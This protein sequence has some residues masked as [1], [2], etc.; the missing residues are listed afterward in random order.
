MKIGFRRVHFRLEWQVAEITAGDNVGVRGLDGHVQCFQAVFRK[1]IVG[2]HED[3]IFSLRH[4]QTFFP[5]PRLAGINCIMHQNEPV[6]AGH[7]ALGDQ[8]A[9]VGGAIINQDYFKM[10]KSLSANG[11]KAL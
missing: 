7:I 10:L 1:P 5:A 11:L 2:I 8:N 6:V 4:V 9:G 3:D